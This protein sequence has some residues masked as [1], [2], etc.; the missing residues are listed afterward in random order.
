MLHRFWG[1]GAG[2]LLAL[3]V[4]CERPGEAPAGGDGEASLG[5]VTPLPA[6]REL[7]GRA[8]WLRTLKGQGRE[9][10]AGLAYDGRGNM[11]LALNSDD[12]VEDLFGPLRVP[13]P[14]RFVV[15]KYGTGGER[16]WS[17]SLPGFAEAI[18]AGSQGQVFVAGRNPE[19]VDYGSG[20]LRQ[21]RFLMR[22]DK[23]GDIAWSRGLEAMELTPRLR[24]ERAEVDGLG[25]VLLAGTRPDVDV[26]SVPMVVKVD[27]K[28]ALLWT[29]HHDAPGEGTGV[30]TDAEG[31]TYVA[32]LL[33]P[34][35]RDSIPFVLK[36]DVRGR[37]VWEQRLATAQGRAMGVAAQGDR[38]LVVG[39][40]SRSLTFRGTVHEARGGEGRGFVAGFDREGQPRWAR[41]LG[42]QGLGISMDAR[43]GAVVVGRYADGDDLGAGPEAGV[44]G[45]TVN[46]FM[47]KLGRAEGDVSWSHAFAMGP[48]KGGD[49]SQ[50]RFFVASSRKGESAFL[51]AQLA[52]VDFGTGP[53][54]APVGGGRELFFGGFEP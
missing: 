13:G 5:E 36:L 20:A 12:A 28:G 38:V 17:L 53:L 50:D 16:V 46:L 34:S 42:R 9:S 47:V 33:R 37:R 11:L 35:R 52:P 3:V 45:S 54:D 44:P 24:V 4:G 6:G 26:E 43:E 1:W 49:L 40:F 7:S 18:A 25:N 39:T 15:A 8:R 51:G 32:G 29:Y 21:G 2:V 27:A 30:A 19:G 10:A 14:G 31:N 22:L 48:A 41:V 23:D